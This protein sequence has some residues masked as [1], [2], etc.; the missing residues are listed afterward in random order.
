MQT[1]HSTERSVSSVEKKKKHRE[2]SKQSTSR[3]NGELICGSG[4]SS[5]VDVLR[6]RGEN[7]GKT[8]KRRKW[9]E[10]SLLCVIMWLDWLSLVCVVCVQREA[11]TIET[12][13]WRWR[14]E[15]HLFSLFSSSFLLVCFSLEL[16]FFSIQLSSRK[17]SSSIKLQTI[18]HF[19][20][21]FFVVGGDFF[22]YVQIQSWNTA[23]ALEGKYW[24][25]FGVI[26]HSFFSFSYF[27]IRISDFGI[28]KCELFSSDRIGKIYAGLLKFFCGMAQIASNL[29]W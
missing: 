28:W 4:E 1:E 6:R 17:E 7:G 19:A 14:S 8:K 24:N 22:V 25:L 5:E 15:I 3:Q 11:C 12:K 26:F 18:K 2:K 13:R 23:P 21:W 9:N 10:W 20:G 27:L 29:S 16:F